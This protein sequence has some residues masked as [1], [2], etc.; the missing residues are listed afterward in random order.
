MLYAPVTSPC[1]WAQN[2]QNHWGLHGPAKYNRD[3]PALPWESHNCLCEQNKSR[4]CLCT[5]HF[6]LTAVPS[7]FCSLS[8]SSRTLLISTII[9][10][11]Q[12][13]TG[14]VM[15]NQHCPFQKFKRPNPKPSKIRLQK[16]CIMFS[17]LSYEVCIITIK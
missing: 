8:K 3:A 4:S 12:I 15:C 7:F 2:L 1:N 10:E 17:G 6:I 16:Y 9:H 14:N 5:F 11:K 13:S